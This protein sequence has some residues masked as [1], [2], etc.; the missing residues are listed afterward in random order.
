MVEKLIE[1][2]PAGP[3]DKPV[4]EWGA[5]ELLADT[6][7]EGLLRVREVLL[8]PMRLKTS[9][10]DELSGVDVKLQKMMV[11]AGLGAGRLAIRA[12]ESAWRAEQSDDRWTELLA[13][14]EAAKNRDEVGGG[15][16]IEGSAV[17]VEAK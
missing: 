11:E 10:D 3:L 2:L 15:K 7:R 16:V 12:Q 17:P 13:R 9:I 4:S 8:Q 14:T 5:A 6:G 1:T